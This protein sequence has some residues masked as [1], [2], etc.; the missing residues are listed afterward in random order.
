MQSK[1]LIDGINANNL[2]YVIG[3]M[4]AGKSTFINLLLRKILEPTYK[5]YLDNSNKILDVDPGECTYME[6]EIEMVNSDNE[7]IEVKSTFREWDINLREYKERAESEKC[8]KERLREVLLKIKENNKYTQ[9]LEARKKPWPDKDEKKRYILKEITYLKIKICNPN[10]PEN[11]S[12]CL[13]D[14]PG[15]DSDTYSKKNNKTLENL[16]KASKI[17]V[18]VQIEKLESRE[19]LKSLIESLNNN[20]KDIPRILIVNIKD[21][22]EKDF[23]EKIDYVKENFLEGDGKFNKAYFINFQDALSETKMGLDK[24][25]NSD[26]IKIIDNGEFALDIWKEILTTP[27]EFFPDV[28]KR[29]LGQDYKTINF[30][31]VLDKFDNNEIKNKISE[32]LTGSSLSTSIRKYDLEKECQDI[33]IYL[34]RKTKEFLREE[35][36]MDDDEVSFKIQKDLRDLIKK[37]LREGLYDDLIEDFNNLESLVVKSAELLLDSKL[38]SKKDNISSLS[39]SF[40]DKIRKKLKKD[41]SAKRVFDEIKEEFVE[42]LYE[43][44]KKYFYLWESY[45]KSIN[46]V[47]IQ[48]QVNK[49]IKEQIK[50]GKHY[51]SK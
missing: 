8:E 39:H 50:S 17:I 45:S 16:K 19:L 22:K 6:T 42:R 27:E 47:Y 14:T 51:E 15:F 1:W 7:E 37:E 2:I 12:F 32:K 44:V 41:Y 35:I 21:Y 30:E 20:C 31:S 11:M 48:Y 10:I 40:I 5:G 38:K 4:K 29:I 26:E 28:I 43:I 13:V 46:R 34:T 49:K 33:Q 24:L 18:V 23:D 3:I 9:N 25:K 36:E